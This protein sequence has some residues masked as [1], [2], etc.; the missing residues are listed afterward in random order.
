[1]TYQG[2]VTGAALRRDRATARRWVDEGIE[3]LQVG[4]S[5]ARC[6]T[7]AACRRCTSSP[8]GTGSLRNGRPVGCWPSRGTDSEPCGSEQVAALPPAGAAARARAGGFGQLVEVL[9]VG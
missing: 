1:M 9:V 4:R 5:W 8:T 7:C 6:S 2:L 3:Y